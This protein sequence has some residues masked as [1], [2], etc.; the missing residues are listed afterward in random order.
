[1]EKKICSR[2]K[3]E[4]DVCE[5]GKKITTKDGLQSRCNECRKVESKLRKEK[6]PDINKIYWDK[7]KERRKK[8]FKEWYLENPNYSKEWREKNKEK[9]NEQRRIYREKNK[10]KTNEQSRIY[11]EK[12]KERLNEQSR[13]YREKNKEKINEKRREKR[14]ENLEFFR[15]KERMRFEE[16]LHLRLIRNYRTRIKNYMRFNKISLGTGS[17]ELVGLTSEDLKKYIESKFKEGMSWDNYGLYG[18][19]LDHI[20][21]LSS[22]KNEEELK[23]LCHYTN[24]QPLWAFDNLSKCD[25]II[26][27]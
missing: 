23:K 22:A 2:C 19:H 27:D 11:R 5:F 4:K 1:M 12:N 20:I 16:N 15:L 7:N 25:K 26:V 18:W 14:K 13:I 17:L 10:E 24:L 3:I 21:P 9:I 6:Y 8:E